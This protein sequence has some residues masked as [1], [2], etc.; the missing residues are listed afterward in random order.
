MQENR[1]DIQRMEL[2]LRAGLFTSVGTLEK[3]KPEEYDTVGSDP[4]ESNFDPDESD[5]EE[6]E[7]GIEESDLEEYESEEYEPEE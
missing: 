5:S 2:L 3:S 4:E 1:R 6:S 7:Y